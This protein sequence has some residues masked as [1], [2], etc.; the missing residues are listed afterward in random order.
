[1]AW[2]IIERQQL[3]TITVTLDNPSTDILDVIK[4]GIET[5]SIAHGFDSATG[6]LVVYYFTKASTKNTDG[7]WTKIG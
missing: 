2:Q 7:T 1:M 4:Q 5:G 6:K 3:G